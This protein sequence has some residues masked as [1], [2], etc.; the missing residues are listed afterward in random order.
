MTWSS[1]YTAV[2]SAGYAHLVSSPLWASFHSP[3]ERSECTETKL[4]FEVCASAG[5]EGR[6]WK[7]GRGGVLLS[8]GRL[9]ITNL[10]L[11]SIPVAG[12][13]EC[14]QKCNHKFCTKGAQIRKKWEVLCRHKMDDTAN[15]CISVYSYQETRCPLILYRDNILKVMHINCTYKLRRTERI[16]ISNQ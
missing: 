11:T 14:F 6:G 12:T 15:I 8:L 10:Q 2:V 4:K 9:L 7:G 16:L 1:V 3:A 13:G 5:G